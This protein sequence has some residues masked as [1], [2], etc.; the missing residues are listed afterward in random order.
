MPTHGPGGEPVADP[1]DDV[2]GDAISKAVRMAVDGVGRAPLGEVGPS[3]D[4]PP[5]ADEPTDSSTVADEVPSVPAQSVSDPYELLGVSR[6]A[7]WEEITASY[8]RRARLWHPD[9]AAPAEAERR[10]ELIR[11]LNVAYADLRVRRGR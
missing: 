4:A 6:T 9:G 8:R 5:A 3:D 11:R 7:S 10:Q 1:I 2:F